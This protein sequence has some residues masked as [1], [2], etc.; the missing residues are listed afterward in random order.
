MRQ[1]IYLM[2]IAFG[3]CGPAYADWVKLGSGAHFNFYVD[4]TT[5]TKSKD[6][7]SA[8]VLYDYHSEQIGPSK[9][10]YRSSKTHYEYKC[11]EKIGRQT[12][13]TRHY[14]PMGSLGPAS[15]N[16]AFQ[17]WQPVKVGTVAAYIHEFV[18]R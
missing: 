11:Q 16:S 4:E 14:G 13:L 5:L 18:C 17:V 1:K 9:E 7:A 15:T 12:Y 10:R 8:L 2:L 6:N 3:L